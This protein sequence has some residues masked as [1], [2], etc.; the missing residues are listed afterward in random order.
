MK[1]NWPYQ[2]LLATTIIIG[3]IFFASPFVAMHALSDA[4]KN[5]KTESKQWQSQVETPYFT[6]YASKVLESL[7]KVKMSLDIKNKTTD[8]STAM[9]DYTFAL[10]G[11]ERQAKKLASAQGFAHFICG[12]LARFPEPPEQDKSACWLMEGNLTWLSP[13]RVQISYH[14][15]ESNWVSHLYLKRT[16]LFNWKAIDLKLPF[17]KMLALLEQQLNSRR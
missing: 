9:L 5:N 4:V 7:L 8:P 6:D 13:T 15:P 11:V 14:N 12:E 10:S 3:I 17:E 2:L 1:L 16:G